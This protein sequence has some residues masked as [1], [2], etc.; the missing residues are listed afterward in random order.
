MLVTESLL[1]EQAGLLQK[2]VKKSAGRILMEQAGVAS[3]TIFDVFL[4]HSK[5]DEQLILGA[6]SL[7]EDQGFS[8]YVDWVEDPHLDRS[9]VS[10]ETAEILK[11]RMNQCG[12]LIYAHSVN[13]AAS[14]W[15]PWELG[16]F[17]G[18]TG[19]VA[20]L[21][22]VAGYENEYGANEYLGL[23]PYLDYIAPKNSEEPILWVNRSFNVYADLEAW[24]R[25]NQ[26]IRD[27]TPT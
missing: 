17:D 6:R 23:Y 27:R 21:P 26:P 1:R 14:T 18:K 19:K 9:K 22:I 8:V 13:S 20:I 3:D 10:V 25:K 2:S 4:S 5:A 11:Q 24:L 7:L 16:Y 15:M 12:M